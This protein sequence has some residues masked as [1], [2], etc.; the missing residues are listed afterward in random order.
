[1]VDSRRHDFFFFFF[2]SNFFGLVGRRGFLTELT[3]PTTIQFKMQNKIKFGRISRLINRFYRLCQ[4]KMRKLKFSIE[5]DFTDQHSPLLSIFSTYLSIVG[6]P[7][8]NT[9]AS[10]LYIKK[11]IVCLGNSRRFHPHQQDS[12]F[13][14][15]K[16]IVDLCRT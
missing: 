1:M 5:T 3:L 9:K 12:F 2:N 13:L 8:S 11:T 15:K 4:F 6:T 14:E 7:F 16:T 10:F